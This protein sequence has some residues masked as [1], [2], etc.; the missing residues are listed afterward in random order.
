[1]SSTFDKKPVFYKKLIRFRVYSNFTKIE[2]SKL[3]ELLEGLTIEYDTSIFDNV[4]EFSLSEKNTSIY[5]F[6]MGK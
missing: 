6:D 5:R 4:G 2:D 3:S 1:M